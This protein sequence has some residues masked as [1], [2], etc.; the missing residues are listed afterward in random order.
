MPA[1]F[2]TAFGL[3]L[4]ILFTIF[5]QKYV[6]IASDGHRPSCSNHADKYLLFSKLIPASTGFAFLLNPRFNP[7][8]Q[9]NGA[10]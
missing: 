3:S 7:L 4:S 9:G 10:G 1:Y 8:L 5:R 2:F 6:C